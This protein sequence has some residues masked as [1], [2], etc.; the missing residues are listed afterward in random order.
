MDNKKD[1][2]NLKKEYKNP[3]DLPL[4]YFGSLNDDILT[5]IKQEKIVE[6][7]KV[8]QLN[9]IFFVFFCGYAEVRLAVRGV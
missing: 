4:N 5:K 7:T 6:P 2:F 8:F 3:Y 9:F 1:I